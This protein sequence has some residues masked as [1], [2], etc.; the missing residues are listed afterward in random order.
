VGSTLHV[1]LCPHKVWREKYGCAKC[2]EDERSV[3]ECGHTKEEHGRDPSYPLATDC[4]GCSCI[5]F[6]AKV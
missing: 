3:C 5:A 6:E 1:K 4:E 2:D